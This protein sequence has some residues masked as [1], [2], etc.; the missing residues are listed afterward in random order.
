MSRR[1]ATLVEL[2]VAFAILMVAS[3]LATAV[4]VTYI[5][6]H[7]SQKHLTQA[8]SIAQSKVE[9]LLVLY[10]T[11]PQLRGMNGPEYYDETGTPSDSLADYRV[12]WTGRPHDVLDGVVELQVIV[13]W[14]ER[15]RT[16]RFVL[17]TARTG[18]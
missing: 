3:T 4:A 5:R 7:Q 8:M 11:D 18:R 6:T 13:N 15:R 16:R 2:L 14:T 12:Q 1:G 17:D 9:D 10:P